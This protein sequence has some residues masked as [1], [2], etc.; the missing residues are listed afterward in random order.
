[1]SMRL[2]IEVGYTKL[3]LPETADGKALLEALGSSVSVKEEYKDGNYS[4]PPMYVPDKTSPIIAAKYVKVDDIVT[5]EEADA[6]R[7]KKLEKQF[8]S[9]SDSSTKMKAE[10]KDL[11]YEI[12]A[13]KEAVVGPPTKP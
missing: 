6:E 9:A 7:V 2:L 13:I 12:A 8:R 11:K 4:G 5:E 1:M 3:L 10:I